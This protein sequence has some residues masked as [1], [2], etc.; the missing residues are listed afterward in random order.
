MIPN[1]YIVGTPKS[2]T[3]SLFHYLNDHPE[4]FMCPK[5][6]P[7]FFSYQDILQQKL[8]YDEKG[9]AHQKEYENLFNNVTSEKAIGEASVSYLFYEKVPSR[10]KKAVPDA[11][12]I[13]ILRNPIDR[14]FSHYLMDSRLGYVNLPFEDIVGKK[15]DHPL[16]SLYFQQFI[17]L[18]FYYEQVKR[19]LDTFGRAQVQIYLND[20]LKKDISKV[21]LAMYDFLEIDRSLMPDLEKQYN[22]YQKPRNP[23][24]GRLYTSKQLRQIARTLI[25]SPLVDKVKN[26]LLVKGQKPKVSPSTRELLN[27]LFKE[28]ILQTADLIGRDL[29]HW[30]TQRT[31]SP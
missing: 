18:G 22:V 7:N 26:T 15:G 21:I 9:I 14:G 1:F 31:E 30:C 10:I 20:D 24:F 16:L 28:N 5:K 3:T 17:E 6:E 12:I 2:G 11:K 19:Y 23:L 25:P 8:Y 4:V 29:S 13:I 27:N